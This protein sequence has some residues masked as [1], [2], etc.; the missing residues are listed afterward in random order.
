MSKSRD[1]FP[2]MTR[3]ATYLPHNRQPSAT[4]AS[5]GVTYHVNLVGKQASTSPQPQP[6]LT[7]TCKRGN[8]SAS[9]TFQSN[10]APSL[11]LDFHRRNSRTNNEPTVHTS[12]NSLRKIF[13]R[14]AMDPSYLQAIDQHRDRHHTS[15][16][17]WQRRFSPFFSFQSTFAD[18]FIMTS[19]DH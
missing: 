11:V 7:C 16:Y 1:L 3:G 6:Q 12:A 14:R 17:H 2:N 18:Y 5:G 19:V 10:P 9:T 4:T 13:S 8:I 15:A